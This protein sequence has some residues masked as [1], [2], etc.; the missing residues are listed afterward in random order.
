MKEAHLE[1]RN[2]SCKRCRYISGWHNVDIF[3]FPPLAPLEYFVWI[4]RNRQEESECGHVL[5]FPTRHIFAYYSDV[6]LRDDVN[7][8]EIGIL[9]SLSLRKMAYLAS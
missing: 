2:R 4:S 8:P 1:Y 5:T 7:V 3:A 9:P 6:A